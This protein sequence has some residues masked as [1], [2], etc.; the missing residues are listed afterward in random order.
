[1]SCADHWA[2][3]E[4]ALFEA[5]KSRLVLGVLFCFLSLS[6][7]PSVPLHPQIVF[8]EGNLQVWKRL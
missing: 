3:K 1:M 6:T 4:L 5:V 7:G 8:A 2:P